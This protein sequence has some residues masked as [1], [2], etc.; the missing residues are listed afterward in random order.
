MNEQQPQAAADR[1][2]VLELRAV[3]A[4]LADNAHPD[5]AHAVSLAAAHIEG[6]NEAFAVAVRDK[7]GLE[8]EV[9][10]LQGLLSRAHSIIADYARGRN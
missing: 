2:L 4:F 9:R 5:G 3:S 8:A 10:R 1:R 7:R 6:H